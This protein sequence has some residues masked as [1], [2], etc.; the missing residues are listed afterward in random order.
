VGQAVKDAIDIGY[1]L[2]DTA[3]VYNNEKEIGEAI[4]SK[5]SQGNIQRENLFI[6][7]KLWSTFHR[8]DLV[9][10]SLKSSLTNLRLDYIDLYLV[11]WPFALQEDGD[12]F[13]LSEDGK[14]LF[15]DVDF[16]DTWK[17]MEQIYKKG[18]A[19]SIGVSNF[20]RRQLDRL[21]KSAKVLPVTNQVRS[22]RVFVKIYEHFLQVECHPYL[23]QIKMSSFL[24]SK[25][26]MLMAYSPLGSADRPW[27]KPTDRVLLADSKL[28]KI[29]DKYEKTPAQIVLRY[30]IQRGHIPIPKSINKERL[31]ENI[32][33]F[34][35]ELKKDE[36][37][38]I[39]S[40]NCN[41]RLCAY[42][43]AQDHPDYPFTKRDEY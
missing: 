43:E 22:T 24:E 27:A 39:S 19:K 34:N 20:N 21:L 30:Q 14:F 6:T 32:D 35:F 36:V 2:I 37:K 26:M 28:K 31:L 42:E 12:L 4:A 10:P 18:L 8:P 33:I 7:S 11:H 16:L 9:E 40:L 1:R 25:G 41:A 15:S 23:T 13:P 29:A 5:I 3:V 17:A 38:T